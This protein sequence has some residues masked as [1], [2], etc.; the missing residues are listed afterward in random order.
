MPDAFAEF[1][2]QK[3]GYGF[4]YTLSLGTEP[5]VATVTAPPD[6]GR[7]K[8]VGPLDVYWQGRR[9]FRLLDARLDNQGAPSSTTSTP[10]VQWTIQD[11]R[12]KWQYGDTLDGDYN[13]EE[14]DGKLVREK[15]PRELATL[16]F[17]AL[18][19][20]GVDVS[21]LPDKPRPPTQWIAASPKQELDR[22]CSAYNC[23][24]A[25][26]PFTNKAYLVKLGTGRAAPNDAYKSRSDSFVNRPRPDAITII[27]GTTLFQSALKVD[28]WLA[29]E[30]DG[31]YVE[32]DQVSYKPAG[33]WETVWPLNFA[34]LNTTY[35]DKATGET[36]YHRDL[37][38]RSIWRTARISGQVA[39]GFSPEALK[40]EWNEPQSVTDL[41]PFTG[42]V[43]EKDPL[44]G[45]RL[46]AYAR[47]V[48]LDQRVGMKNS[49]AKTRWPGSVQINSEQ[50]IVTFDRP[51]FKLTTDNKWEQTTMELIA[52]YEVSHEGVP[53]R[54]DL[55]RGLL[56]QLVAVGEHEDLAT[57]SEAVSADP[58]EQHGFSTSCGLHH[59]RA[60]AG[61]QGRVDGLDRLGLVVAQSELRSVHGAPR[62]GSSARRN[63]STTSAGAMS[64]D[65]RPPDSSTSFSGGQ[66]GRY[67]TADQPQPTVLSHTKPW[68]SGY[69]RSSSALVHT[70]SR[71]S[72]GG[73]G[74]SQGG[75]PE[76]TR[77]SSG[78]V[79]RRHSPS[80]TG[81]Y[82]TSS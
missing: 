72:S 5:G 58:R 80:A 42:S 12:W 30:V 28:E 20:E 56:D 24:P 6:F 82:S 39:G 3:R 34:A 55:R 1:C 14:K 60:G 74:R 53:V 46:D 32:M 57:R 47:G 59:Q 7:I 70:F 33:G 16:C 31:T 11:R 67:L 45:Q 48:F 17:L 8:P 9:F 76:R 50:R 4:S 29:L 22:L 64:L 52:A 61:P 68:V 15:S 51:C 21:A 2:N 13:R 27:G 49:P 75:A 36:L 62:V 66:P 79:R 19:E 40:G 69:S 10:L 23:A 73:Q 71:I 37:A 38:Q 63:W 18:G 41:G 81:S 77:S 26:S 43:L 54:F 44:T 35:T 65:S 25:Y 78:S